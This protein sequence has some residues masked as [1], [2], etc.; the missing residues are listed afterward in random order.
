VACC[1]S[2]AVV[3]HAA[4]GVAQSYYAAFAEWL[5][6][7][8]GAAV[9]T[10]DY[11]DFAASARGHIKDS[12]ATMSAWGILDQQA[13]L[14]ALIARFPDVPIRVI[15]HSLGGLWLSFH[16]DIG[17]VDRVLAVAS[18]PAY[19][20]SHPLSEM[21]RVIWFWWLGGP[22]AVA[23]LGYLPR[24]IGLG[25][26]LPAGVYWQWRRWCLNRNFAAGAFGSSLPW[27]RP[28]N[29]RFELTTVSLTDDA[30][31]PPAI[32]VRLLEFYPRAPGAVLS[33]DPAAFGLSGFGHTGIFRKRNQVAWPKLVE[34]LVR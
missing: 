9:L 11:R 15:G 31:I 32:S 33:L 8:H 23:A 2:F 18:G 19:W 22:V 13:A 10:Y 28:E 21:A 4:T 26:E 16:D 17:K 5:V 14:S 24:W 30:L 7:T 12:K 6:R 20:L 29:A 27:P 1:G 3:L 34:A 25:A